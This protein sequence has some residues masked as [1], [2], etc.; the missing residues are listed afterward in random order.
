MREIIYEK[1]KITISIDNG[2]I[3]FLY[4]LFGIDKV[5]D[6][7]Y[8]EELSDEDEEGV[9]LYLSSLHLIFLESY[10]KSIPFQIPLPPNEPLTKEMMKFI[11]MMLIVLIKVRPSD[12]QFLFIKTLEW[13]HTTAVPFPEG[14][15]IDHYFKTISIIDVMFGL[16]SFLIDGVE[17]RAEKSIEDVTEQCKQM[18]KQLVEMKIEMNRMKAMV[19]KMKEVNM[20]NNN[21]EVEEK[22]LS[23]DDAN[24]S[25]GDENAS[26][27]ELSEDQYEDDETEKKGH[28]TSIINRRGND[29]RWVDL[30][31]SRRKIINEKNKTGNRR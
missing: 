18:N 15:E 8:R 4:P 16:S 12:E 11:R 31:Q 21:E 24:V 2:K 28:Y 10:R 9:G 25:D 20:L 19:K 3:I 26:E 23:E 22:N 13:L 17:T 7:P 6:L 30:N 14:D 1:R 29:E 5:L 27:E